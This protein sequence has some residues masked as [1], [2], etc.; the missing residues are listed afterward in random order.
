MSGETI[1]VRGALGATTSRN[2]HIVAGPRARLTPGGVF[3]FFFTGLSGSGTSPV[4]SRSTRFYRP[5]K[6]PAP[7]RSSSLSVRTPP[8]SLPSGQM[9]TRLR[10]SIEGFCRP[11]R[12]RSTRSQAFLATRQAPSLRP[13]GN[14][15]RDLATTCPSCPLRGRIGIPHLPKTAV[16]LITPPALPQQSRSTASPLQLKDGHAP[17]SRCSA[18]RRWRGGR[19]GLVPTRPPASTARGQEY[20]RALPRRE[21]CRPPGQSAARAVRTAHDRSP[22]S[23]RLVPPAVSSGPVS[24]IRSDRR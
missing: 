12:S 11:A 23:D 20:T 5:G 18:P 21:T 2:V 3:F 1:V 10:L 17:V 19:K 14:Y 6:G 16:G 15:H 24:P 13:F 8:A 9:A 22:S 7:L 4:R